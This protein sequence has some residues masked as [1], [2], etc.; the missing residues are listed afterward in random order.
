MIEHRTQSA[1]EPLD[2][3]LRRQSEWILLS[4]AV[5]AIA[6][7]LQLAFLLWG[8]HQAPLFPLGG[9]PLIAALLLAS[10]ACGIA[11]LWRG[12]AAIARDFS[13]RDDSEH[14]Q[15]VIRVIFASIVFDYAMG[16]LSLNPGDPDIAT[17]ALAMGIGVV[18]GWL[19]LLH[20]MMS[21]GR[22][23]WRRQLAMLVDLGFLSIYLHF[24][25]G[26]SAAWFGLYLWLGIGYGLRYGLRPLF[27]S[28]ALAFIGFSAVIA[29]TPL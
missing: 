7:P 2:P 13:V 29:T 3:A 23:L 17:A 18:V 27:Q 4:I 15:I 14:E 25:G 22:S 8:Q 6:S 10:V 11:M 28:T 19:I 26:S 20:L 16:A 1:P 24:G 12:L 9:L 21:P 5:V